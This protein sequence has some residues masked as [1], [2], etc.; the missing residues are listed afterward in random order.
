MTVHTMENFDG[1]RAG[2]HRI[3]QSCVKSHLSPI[4]EQ[5][6]G[7]RTGSD[8]RQDC[9]RQDHIAAAQIEQNWVC[10]GQSQ[11]NRPIAGGRWPSRARSESLTNN[12]PRG[13]E[14]CGC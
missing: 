1:R 4:A 3:C 5:V 13:A 11:L 12:L 2:N 8:P 7:Q 14:F 6:K 10:H 9:G